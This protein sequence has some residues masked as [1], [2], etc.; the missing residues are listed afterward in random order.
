MFWF[1][2]ICCFLIYPPAIFL[3][4]IN[5]GWLMENPDFGVLDFLAQL[6]TRSNSSV[7]KS[8]SSAIHYFTELYGYSGPKILRAPLLWMGLSGSALTLWLLCYS[9]VL[10]IRPNWLSASPSHM[11]WIHDYVLPCIFLLVGAPVVA[12]ALDWKSRNG[13][14][15]TADQ[16]RAG[17]AKWFP[18]FADIKTLR[19]TIFN[20]KVPQISSSLLPQQNHGLKTLLTRSGLAAFSVAAAGFYGAAKEPHDLLLAAVAIFGVVFLTPP[21]LSIVVAFSSWEK[22][23]LYAIAVTVLDAHETLSDKHGKPII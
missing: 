8:E 23:P 11:V 18:D 7:S 12:M 4:I 3:I 6:F 19:D 16:K 10:A 15:L 9:I 17:L 1:L 13:G 21:I 5:K 14:Q 2:V 22:K 20:G